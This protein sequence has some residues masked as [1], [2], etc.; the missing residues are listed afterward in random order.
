MKNILVTGGAGYVGSV[1]VS[2]L[3][4]K[5]F[6][7]RVFDSFLFA[8]ESLFPK[9]QSLEVYRADLR[10]TKAVEK[11]LK[12]I[13][14]V[15]HLAGISNDPS[16]DLNP[17]L[18]KE[19][20]IV[21]SQKL[22][23][24]CREFGIPRFINASSSSVYGVKKEA[25]VTEDLS[26]E[27]LTLYSESKV[28]IEKY[29]K[30]NKGKMTAVSIRPATV[31]GYS[32][33]MRLDL[34]VNILTHFA[35]RKGKIL[36][37][38]GSQKRPNIHIED[39]TDLYVSLLSTP[40]PLIDGEVFN[41]C[42]ANHTVLEI[43]ELVR[44]TVNPHLPILIEPTNDLRSYHINAQKIKRVLDFVPKR[45]IKDAITDMVAAFADHRITDP[46][47]DKY[48]NV[49]SLKKSLPV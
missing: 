38:G 1:L 43:A 15:I 34:T 47:Q 29:L 35:V 3:L 37:F 36:V 44:N 4:R 32:P 14:A 31:C 23:D 10:D 18:T 22:I 6:N 27:P 8:D 19:V 11:A 39:I 20:N 25:E 16:S 7:V 48:Y 46:D 13:D 12:N 17:A 49:R 42:G 24:L 40:A 5:S 28:V 26:L 9:M 21:A 33:R 2:K 45:T 30:E 41:A